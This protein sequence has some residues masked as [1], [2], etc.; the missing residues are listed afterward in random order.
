MV[1]DYYNEIVKNTK[2][3]KDV[4]NPF[5]HKFLPINREYLTPTGFKTFTAFGYTKDDYPKLSLAI[6]NLIKSLINTENLNEQK[7]YN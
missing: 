7:N 5:L 3:L 4:K 6:F 1:K 2:I